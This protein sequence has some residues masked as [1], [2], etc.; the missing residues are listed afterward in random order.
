MTTFELTQLR[1]QRV[2]G[3]AG[4][5]LHV[6][7]AGNPDGPPVL[8]IH[9]I[10]QSRMAWRHQLGSALGQT[11]RLVA[12]DLR[13]HGQS[14][15]PR[16]AYGE[17]FLWA[18]DVNAVITELGLDRPILC[19][20][21]YGGVVIGDYLRCY[22]ERALGGIVLVA[23]VTRLGETV[24]PFLAP[25]FVDLFPGLF[26]TDVEES[27][28]ALQD[29]VRLCTSA[30]LD[31]GEFYSAVGYNTVVSPQVRRAM[32]SRTVNYDDLFA[33][34]ETPLLAVHGLD[35]RIVLP[36]MSEHLARVVLQARTSFYAGVGHTPFREDV[37]R[38]DAELLAFATAR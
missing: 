6:D 21:S 10:S 28:T 9:G 38:F 2:T 8:F 15:R 17:P 14:D 18:D 12:M 7:E 29:F 33:R 31:P 26:S 13:G 32:M 25:Q 34:L 5:E 3:G 22:G 20:W 19:G 1:S 35:D 4:C 16:D 36:A 27:S 30:D 23:A 24:M 37:A 11:M